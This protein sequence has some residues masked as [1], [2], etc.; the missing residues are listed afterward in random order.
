MVQRY[1]VKKR[2]HLKQLPNVYEKNL[3]FLVDCEFVDSNP[4]PNA[5]KCPA[6]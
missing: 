1:E 3:L 6:F 4:R 2:L 5:P